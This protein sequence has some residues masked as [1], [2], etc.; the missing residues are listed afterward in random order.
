[1]G[2]GQHP[3][4]RQGAVRSVVDK[5]KS[6]LVVID[7]ASNPHLTLAKACVIARHAGARL[8]L[9]MCDAEHGYSLRQAYDAR[10][11]KEAREACLASARRY[12]ESLRQAV[13]AP[14]IEVTV[15]VACE[16]P[17]YQGIMSKVYRSC[18]DLVIRAARASADRRTAPGVDAN[19]LQLVRTCPVPLM[20]THGKPWQ[21][22]PRFAAAI[23][24]S[25]G[26]TPGLASATLRTSAYLAR[27]C[28]AGLDVL[29]GE[30][31]TESD[32]AVREE[33]ARLAREVN[34]PPER[35]HVVKGDPARAVPGFAAEQ[36]YDV[37][38][39]GALSHR[40]GLAPIVGTLTGNVLE[41]LDCDCVLVKPGSYR[42]PASPPVEAGATQ[43]L[44]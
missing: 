4:T 31:E 40:P 8:E 38:V 28:G 35:V 44:A 22:Q 37:M 10:G 19:A 2:S 43:S 15:D 9:F 23:D 12:L 14:D 5:L 21:P 24:V 36:G 41:T 7:R 39:L 33:L 3:A 18:P 32:P 30:R 1:M 34:V 29:Y 11:V 42:L 16:S 27:S 26:E 6:I 20:L 17:E 13:S 25:P